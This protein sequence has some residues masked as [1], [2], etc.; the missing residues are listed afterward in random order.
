MAQCI[1]AEQAAGFDTMTTPNDVVAM[2]ASTP[3]TENEVWQQLHVGACLVFANGLVAF[4]DCP[5]NAPLMSIEE[6]KALAKKIG[7]V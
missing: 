2:I 4:Q 3:L 5:N 7:E 1:D 6:G